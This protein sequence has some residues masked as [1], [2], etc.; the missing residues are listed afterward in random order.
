[1]TRGM[2]RLLEQEHDMGTYK[3]YEQNVNVVV[4]RCNGRRHVRIFRAS[5]QENN[6]QCNRTDL[7]D[8]KLGEQSQAILSRSDI[9]QAQDQKTLFISFVSDIFSQIKNKYFSI[10]RNQTDDDE[11]YPDCMAL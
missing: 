9:P 2:K 10:T 8:V 7:K 6:E 3:K 1:M 5:D 11:I 4:Q